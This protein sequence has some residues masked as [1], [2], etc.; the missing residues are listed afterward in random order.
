MTGPLVYLQWTAWEL[1]SPTAPQSILDLHSVRAF[2]AAQ[3]VTTVGYGRHLLASPPAKAPAAAAKAPAAAAKAPA[4]AAKAP[5]AAAKAPAAAAK[6]PAAAA[7]AP[8]AAVKTPAT[9][10]HLL[11]AAPAPGSASPLRQN[12]WHI[13]GLVESDI[14]AVIFEGGRSRFQLMFFLLCDHE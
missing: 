11:A 13:T 3:K 10:R 12:C 7:K 2:P 9:G 8:A 4:A 1:Y 14:F 6:A 5:A